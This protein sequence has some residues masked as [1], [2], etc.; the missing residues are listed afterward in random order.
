MANLHPATDSDTPERRSCT[1]TD[2][3]GPFI[4]TVCAGGGNDWD[5]TRCAQCDASDVATCD[6]PE[7]VHTHAEPV[8]ITERGRAT[9]RR[10]RLAAER[11][12]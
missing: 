2:H 5:R 6:D 12:S 10:L 7:I 1:P 9:L 8:F 3:V 4:V 11:S